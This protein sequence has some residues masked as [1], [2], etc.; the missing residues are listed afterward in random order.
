MSYT[1]NHTVDQQADRPTHLPVICS[2][3]GSLCNK[4]NKKLKVANTFS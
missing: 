1:Y 4:Y 3:P 2:V